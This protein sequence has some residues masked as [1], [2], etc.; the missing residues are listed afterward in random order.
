MIKEKRNISKCDKCLN[1]HHVLSENGYHTNCLLDESSYI[2]CML[3]TKNSYI[4]H[5]AYSLKGEP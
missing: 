5:P 2:K 3:G 1:G 4:E